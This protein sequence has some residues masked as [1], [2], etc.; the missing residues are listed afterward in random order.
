[1]F[2]QIIDR[3]HIEQNFHSVAKVIP[4]DGT[5]WCWGGDESKTL[6]WGFAMAPHR[7]RAL[8]EDFYNLAAVS[9]EITQGW[10][11]TLAVF[12]GADSPEPSLLV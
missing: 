10:L 3:K 7:L 11:H 8:V 6:A 5:R 1:M 12:T 4:R 9:I 2:S